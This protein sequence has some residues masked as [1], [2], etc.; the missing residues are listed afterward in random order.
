MTPSSTSNQTNAPD[1]DHYN[2]LA[3]LNKDHAKFMTSK[4]LAGVEEHGGHLRDWTPLQLIDEALNE[5]ID[6]FVYLHT[7]REKLL[8]M[9]KS[10]VQTNK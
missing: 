4:Y 7:L 8:A 5:C 9:E 3:A 10:D 1:E 2:H 6:Q